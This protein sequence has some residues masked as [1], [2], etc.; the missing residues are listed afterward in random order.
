MDS[1]GKFAYVMDAGCGGGVGGYVSMYTINP[2]TGALASIGPPV[3]TYG[4][5][6]EYGDGVNAGSLTVDPLASSPT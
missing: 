4:Y 3:S 2:T 5:G 6:I 1:T